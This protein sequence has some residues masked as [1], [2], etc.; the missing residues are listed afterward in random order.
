MNTAWNTVSKPSK[1]RAQ[2]SRVEGAGSHGGRDRG[3][4][5][6]DGFP[7]ALRYERARYQTQPPALTKSPTGVAIASSGPAAPAPDQVPDAVSATLSRAQGS[8]LPDPEKWNR[9]VGADVSHAKLVT[10]EGAPEAAASISARAFTVGDR[11]FFARG[12]DAQTDGG[13]LL[14]HELTHVAQQKGGTAPTSWDKTPFVDYHDNREVAARSHDSAPQVSNE[15][16]IARDAEPDINNDAYR[17]KF[18]KQI[19]DGVVD[20]LSKHDLPSGSRFVTFLGPLL[21]GPALVG[22][23]GADL[24]GKLNLWITQDTVMRA[25]QHARP[26]GVQEVEYQNGDKKVEDKG[27]DGP[28]RWFPDVALEIGAALF[29]AMRTSLDRVVPRYQSAAVALG[30]AAEDKAKAN[31]QEVPTPKVTDV[32]ASSQLD[33]AM[34]QGLVNHAH[35]DYAGYR[36]AYPN[37]KGKLGKLRAVELGVEAPK[38]GMFYARV[39]S[40]ADASPEEVANQLFGASTATGEL[41]IVAAPLFGFANA[42]NLKPLYADKLKAMGVNLNAQVFDPAA[43]AAKGPMADEIAHNQGKG[44]PS[45]LATKTA[46]LAA[47]DES[48]A[49][50]PTIEKSG[51]AFGMGHNPVVAGLAPL[52]KELTDRRAK[53]R[54]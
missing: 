42:S 35:F 48:V 47:V 41:Q 15:H 24:D 18:T 31:L 40:P 44:I 10:G 19:G 11:V 3:R 1:R 27:Q 13:N 53:S 9:R 12:N 36:R 17:K 54:A 5:S 29:A 46:V 22:V 25:I 32:I 39:K 6:E 14:A 49:I 2:G 23:G 21:S 38:D 34:V 50:I 45:K 43:A 7:A 20:Y 33:L 16:A 26:K 37:E 28:G 8:P 52:K 30:I 4:R 51:A